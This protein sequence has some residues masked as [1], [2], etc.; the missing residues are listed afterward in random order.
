M[1]APDCVLTYFSLCRLAIVPK[2]PKYGSAPANIRIIHLP[3]GLH[4]SLYSGWKYEKMIL[5]LLFFYSE[6]IN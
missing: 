1:V 4:S 5:I 2:A 3:A 6:R